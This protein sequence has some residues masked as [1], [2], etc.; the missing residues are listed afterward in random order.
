[1]LDPL[2]SDRDVERITGR[3]RSTLQKDRVIGIGIPFVRIGR[4]VRYRQSDVTAF[5]DALPRCRS[6]SE[7]DPNG[8]ARWAVRSENNPAAVSSTAARTERFVNSSARR[9]SRS[10]RCRQPRRLDFARINHAAL[11]RLPD[12]LGR[13]LPGGRMEGGEYVALNPRRSDHRPGSFKIN[14]DTGQWADFGIAG[15]RGRD[16]V[17]LA[18]YLGGIG[19]IEAAERLAAM[20]G[21]VARDG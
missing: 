1:M 16:V 18:A 19:Q 9:P 20:L 2:L 15:L 6:T 10:G 5:L 14:L 17:S 12:I 11:A 13:W 8:E 4:L 3:A 7:T 21:I